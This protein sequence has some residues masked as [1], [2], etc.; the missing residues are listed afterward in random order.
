MSVHE[1]ESV[2]QRYRRLLTDGGSLER[3]NAFSD[4]IFAIAMT[5][6]VLDVRVPE[7]VGERGLGPALLDVLPGYL[8]FVLS[9]VVIGMVWRSHH[10][11]FRA[12]RGYDQRLL[13]LNLLL[14]L[15][16]ASLPF[17]TALLGRYGDD[18]LAA[19][20]YAASVALVGLSLTAIW[21]Y[22]W[23]R[24]LIDEQITPR[25]FR[26]VMVSS[27]INP[28]VF[29]LSI[30]VSLLAGATWGELFW[31]LA[32]PFGLVTSALSRKDR[33]A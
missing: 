19:V 12:I 8:T 16:V 2:V 1:S 28:A 29:L 33:P 24:G 3:T 27:L 13:R 30:P 31:I 9:F 14:L 5:L 10:R 4:A 11:K 22:A 21:V 20:I 25:V 7:K 26:Y 15:F 23:R 6:L 32:L 17:P 18:P